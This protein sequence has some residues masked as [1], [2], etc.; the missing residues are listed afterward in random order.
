[1]ACL[2]NCQMDDTTAE[3][4]LNINRQFYQNLAAHFSA[5]RLRLQPGIQR[6][7]PR[8]SS[9]ASLLDLGCGNGEL[10]RSLQRRGYAGAYLGADASPALLE[11]ARRLTPANGAIRFALVDLAEQNWHLRLAEFSPAN[12]IPCEIACAFAVLHHLPGE[13]LRLEILSKIHRLLQA[14]GLFIHSE[15]QFLSSPRLQKRLQAWEQAGLSAHT[16]DPGDY[17]LDWRHGEHGLRYVHQFTEAELDA[18]AIRSGFLIRETFY[19]D[20]ENR[21]SGLYQVWVRT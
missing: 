15:W 19:S 7:L 6:L 11:I 14:E 5:T 3:R 17:L 2:Y 9:A 16:V 1:M 20:G 13:A 4:L 21:R 18:L 10:A 12:F 8:L